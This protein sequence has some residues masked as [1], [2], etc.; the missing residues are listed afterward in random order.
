MVKAVL[1][2]IAIAS[3]SGEDRNTNYLKALEKHGA[4][5][6]LVRPGGAPELD[7]V[8]GLLL[9]GGGDLG[10]P[11]YAHALDAAERA[12]LGR[13]EPERDEFEFG[14]LRWA[15]DR[16]LPVLGICRGLQVM[17]AFAGGRLIPDLPLWKVRQGGVAVVHRGAEPGAPQPGDVAHGIDVVAGSRLAVAMG[18]A[19][20]VEVNSCHHQAL[21]SLPSGLVAGA[22]AADG[23]IEGIEDPRRAFWVGV[24][25]H[26]ERMACNEAAAS[27]LF[28]AFL[29]GAGR[30]R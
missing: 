2:T 14:L 7:R 23:I 25:F 24:Q 19:G 29:A 21:A 27:A 20:R 4:A 11:Y 12:T 30:S 9:T 26:P 1:P 16:D 6:R 17:G 22:V 28:Q 3:T 8:H 10:E 18:V 5:W 13:I 15:A